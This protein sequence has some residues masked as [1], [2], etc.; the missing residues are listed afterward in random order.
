MLVPVLDAFEVI[1]V[2]NTKGYDLINTSQIVT[3]LIGRRRYATCESLERLATEG[4]A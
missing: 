1:G 4:A 3:V 2:G